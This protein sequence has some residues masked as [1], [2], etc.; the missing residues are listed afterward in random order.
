M[1]R[2]ILILTVLLSFLS[3]GMH[4]QVAP[5]TKT[6]KAAVS[7]FVKDSESADALPRATIQIMKS[8]TTGMISGGITNSLG[9]YTI[10]NVPEGSYVVKISYI[11]Y[12]NFFRAITIKH[13]QTTLNVGTVMLIPS[14]VMLQSAVVTGVLQ[15]AEVK[16]D[17]IIFNADAFKTPEGSVLEELVKKLPGAE[18][19][20]DGSITVNGKKVTKILVKGKEFFNNDTEMAMKNLPTEIIDKIKVY[21]KKSDQ[22]RITGI[23]DGNEETVIDLGIKKGMNKGWF[24]NID[25]G[26]GTHD[27]Y[28]TRAMVNRFTDNTQASIVGNLNNTGGGGT[29]TAQSGGI[30]LALDLNKVEINGN[31]RYN[32][33]KSESSSYS[34]SEHFLSTFNQSFTNNRR[35]SLSRSS[36]FNSDFKVEW[37]I[38]SLTTLLFRP[39]VS[40]SNNDSK[41]NGNSVT[42]LSDPYISDDITN[43]LDQFDLLPD[44]IKTNHNQSASSSDGNSK[45]LSGSLLFNHRFQK[46]GRNA[47]LN[48]SGNYSD[49]DNDSYNSSKYKYYQKNSDD[50]IY[51]YRL[52]PSENKGYSIGVTYSEPIV[53]G[54]VLQGSYTLSY[55]SRESDSR[56]FDLGNR[57]LSNLAMQDSLMKYIGYLPDDYTNYESDSLSRYTKDQN[58]NHNINLSLRLN[59]T[60]INM[61]AGVQW[62]PQHQHMEYS[63]LGHDTIATRDYYRISPTL[64]FRY[65]FTKQHYIRLT[66]RGNLT[67]PSI[68]NLFDWTDESDHINISHGN[69]DLQPSFTNNVGL[70]WQNY[71]TSR[72]QNWSANVSFQNTINSISQKTKYIADTGGRETYPENINGN[73]SIST[74]FGFATPLFTEKIMLNTNTSYSHNQNVSFLLQEKDGSRDEYE[75]LKNFVWTNNVS[76][77]L[78]L[79]LRPNSYWDIMASGN[80][81]YSNAD[82]KLI[83]TANKNTWDFGYGLSSTGNFENGWGFNTSINMSSRRGYSSS[84]MNT[85]ELIWNAQI[86]Y[87]FLQGRKATISL[88]AYDLLQ[89]RSNISRMISATQRSDTENNQINNYIMM[90]FIYRFNIFGSKEVRQNMRNA[91]RGQTPDFD[92][93]NFDRMNGNESD[94]NEG[95]GMGGNRGG[96]MGGNRGGGMGGPGG[97]M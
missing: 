19:A 71:I 42:F 89:Q 41:S 1:K 57:Y 25:L 95:G 34:S 88:Q 12:H 7:G 37:K 97:R 17:T 31:V 63:Y 70:Q 26:L 50:F 46:A 86:S 62:Q 77:S 66:Y 4:A 16:E 29:R 48:L 28:A 55:S 94:G 53:A 82:S 52:S 90:H 20:S 93:M 74:N 84:E 15:Q 72:Y 54:L 33:N 3:P 67:Q 2:F 9:G 64:N 22:A 43:P 44:S 76:E 36:S 47:S 35:S 58:T 6:T 13:D 96:G 30:N 11:G 73:W 32:H 59:T 91:R 87:R 8:D 27:L 65:R 5:Q 83:S 23:D 51:R 21:E 68:T 60:H 45:S 18:V 39:N 14:T 10:K 24:G 92:N 69:P 79:T 75:E 56:N 49:S 61:Q 40:F 78:R 85:N 81:K 38:D 80:V